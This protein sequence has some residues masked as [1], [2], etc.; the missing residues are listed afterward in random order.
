V[1]NSNDKELK[2]NIGDAFKLLTNA[3]NKNIQTRRERIHRTVHPRYRNAIL[4]HQ[5]S[6][7]NSLETNYRKKPNH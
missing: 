6:A 7:G 2:Q 3:M 1:Q 4:K 5:H